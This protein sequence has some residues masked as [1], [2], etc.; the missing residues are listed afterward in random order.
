M[1]GDQRA[2]TRHKYVS[3]TTVRTVMGPGSCRTKG[4]GQ[5]TEEE[6]EKKKHRTGP[7]EK[8]EKDGGVEANL[9]EQKRHSGQPKA[10]HISFILLYGS[11]NERGFRVA[12]VCLCVRQAKVESM[13]KRGL[14]QKQ[15]GSRDFS[16]NC[17]LKLPS[18][19]RCCRIT[20]MHNWMQLALIQFIWIRMCGATFI[21]FKF[22]K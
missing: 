3:L 18:Q 1:H 16:P 10:R 5:L 19:M 14:S 6:E 20:H 9:M 21:T 4:E 7:K 17:L 2:N 15:L 22:E 8:M 12:V 11:D 13:I